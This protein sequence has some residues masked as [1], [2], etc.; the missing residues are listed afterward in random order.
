MP[1]IDPH[2]LR[3]IELRRFRGPRGEGTPQPRGKT[4]FGRLGV[5]DRHHTS[6]VA[7]SARP[8]GRARQGRARV[9]LVGPMSP[10]KGGVTTFMLN[11]MASHLAEE[12]EFVPFTTSR[13]PKRDVIDNWGYGSMFRGGLGRI[14]MGALATILHLAAFPFAIVRH[15]IDLVQIQA[16]DYQAFLESVLYALIARSLRRPVLFRIGGAF[17]LFHG[18]SPRI[19]RRWIAASLRLP[20]CLI[21][22]SA[23]ARDYIRRA[24]RT[25]EII[26]LPN[27]SREIDIAERPRS[28]GDAATFLFIAGIEARRK[29]I[30]EV[31]AAARQLDG[32]GC[33]ARFCL[34]AMT[35]SLIQHVGE[36][37]LSN[38][39]MME[40][41]VAHDR[42]LELMRQSD[43]L[44]LPSHGE[45]FPNSLIEAMATGMASIVTPV[46]A[47]P[48]IVEEGGALTVPVGD[49]AALASAIERLAGNPELRQRLGNEAGRIVRARY[50][51]AAL[52]PLAEAYRGLLGR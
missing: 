45:G 49:A 24:G 35:P 9:L 34:L 10:T 17:D 44:L 18:R 3:G 22:Q 38:I 42:V 30:Q 33:P 39:R 6:A 11:L 13:P 20:H 4:V 32:T 46:G 43:V 23:F 40:G 36:L 50:T 28:G 41:P 31:L 1:G 14:L 8:R 5:Q 48:E 21:A 15:R 7:G 26:T 2:R 29:G 16:S 52:P 47:V 37:G 19:V 51:A 25:G 27:W 12:F